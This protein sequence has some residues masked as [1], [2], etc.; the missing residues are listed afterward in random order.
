ME[1]SIVT[2]PFALGNF[3]EHFELLEGPHWR[4]LLV[5]LNW[6]RFGLH[7]IP[8]SLNFKANGWQMNQFG[9]RIGAEYH[10][11]FVWPRCPICVFDL[12]GPKGPTHKSDNSATQIGQGISYPFGALWCT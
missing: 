12:L 8:F 10:V 2:K 11:R 9:Y 3:W 7:V 6:V 1:P 5:I 4:S